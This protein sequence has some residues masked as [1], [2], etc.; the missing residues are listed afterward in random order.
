LFRRVGFS[1]STK[2]IQRQVSILNDVSNRTLVSV[3][4]CRGNVEESVREALD[5]IGGL[6]Q[7]MGKGKTVLIK[8]NFIRAEPSSVGTTT[9]LEVIESVVKIVRETGAKMIIGEASGN[10]YDTEEIFKFVG[11]K[12]RLP[13]VEIQ[14]LDR[15]EIIECEIPE[16]YVLRKVGI[17]KSALEADF[18]IGLPVLKTHNATIVTGALK[19]MMG[20]L[21]QREKWN[22]HLCGLHQSLVDLNKLVKPDLVIMD[23]L[24]CQEGL[25]PT[26]GRPVRMDLILASYDPVAIDTVGTAIME[27]DPKEIKHL[28]L[29]SQQGL[30]EGDLTR[31]EIEGNQIKEVSRKFKRPFALWFF[32]ITGVWQYRIGNML[33]KYFDYDIRNFLRSFASFHLPKPQL[34]SKNCR[35]SGHCLEICPTGAISMKKF[36]QIDY[37]KCNGCMLCFKECV[38]GAYKLSRKPR[39]IMRYFFS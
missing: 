15:T 33:L 39:W 28:Q 35:R 20:V 21:P 32:L 19:N 6:P 31:I 7:D 22:M 3:V 23:A 29:A 13:D 25:G 18:I 38:N 9:S 2:V 27:I 8:P 30:G 17:S 34:V 12:E 26:M 10:Q 14:D 4:E 36:P 16:S 37:K 1:D 24:T 11:L 5:K